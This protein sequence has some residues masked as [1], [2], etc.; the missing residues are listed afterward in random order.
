MIGRTNVAGG[1]GGQT[2]SIRG[3]CNTIGLSYGLLDDITEADMRT[4]MTKYASVAYFR[5]WY[6]SEP[7][8]IDQFIANTYAMKWIGLRDYI[9]D[10]LMALQSVRTKMLASANWEYILKDHVPIMTSDTAPYG[11][12]SSS[13]NY[14]SS[15]YY[16]FDQ[17]NGTT[18]YSQYKTNVAGE[19]LQYQFIN[20]I[21]VKKF[22]YRFNNTKNACDV[23]ISGSNDGTNFTDIVTISL[24]NSI[25]GAYYDINN[26]NYYLYYR[27]TCLTSIGNIPSSSYYYFCVSDIQFYGRSLNVSVPKMTGNTSPYGEITASGDYDTARKRLYAFDGLPSTSS[28]YGWLP[29]G[30]DTF[31][32]AWISYTFPRDV[33]FKGVTVLL[34]GGYSHAVTVRD[35]QFKIVGITSGGVSEDITDTLLVHQ[36]ETTYVYSVDNNK[37]YRTI[38][39][40]ITGSLIAGNTPTTGGGYKL[41]FF[42]VDYSERTDRTY[43]YDHGVEVVPMTKTSS[44]AL[45]SVNVS[46]KSLLRAM[47]G[48]HATTTDRLAC[49]TAYAVANNLPNG[50]ALD[51]VNITGTQSTGFSVI[52]GSYLN[53]T[54][55]WM[56]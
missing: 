13:S 37:A 52:N 25:Y 19:Y 34:S 53:E 1:G 44:S 24:P 2:W 43:L 15:P 7:D 33:T 54:E 23:K 50:F 47:V 22:Y 14:S 31:G 55:L 36:T 17:N 38:R 41:N 21:C 27:L 46:T 9:C 35:M 42:G 26:S 8:M 5:E 28:S 32:S 39:F 6:A 3:W 56:E 48:S 40:V 18:W 30:S 45:S 12:A 4:L 29:A 10:Q 20:P 51:I 16:V 11:T 49:G